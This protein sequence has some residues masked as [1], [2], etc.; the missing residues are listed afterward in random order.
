MLPLSMSEHIS[1]GS[2]DVWKAWLGCIVVALWF[3]GSVLVL[4]DSVTHK[5]H[6]V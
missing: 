5:I 3:D 6:M 4:H 1:P 2:R